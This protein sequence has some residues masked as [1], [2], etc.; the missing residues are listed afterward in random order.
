MLKGYVLQAYLIKYLIKYELIAIGV[1]IAI[2][3]FVIWFIIVLN[4]VTRVKKTSLEE[5]LAGSH[6][7]N[8]YMLSETL[9][10]TR[11]SA[12]S[13]PESNF[14]YLKGAIASG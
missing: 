7:Y 14:S 10:F 5:I 3:T 9:F 13:S 4:K 11:A 6:A 8:A 2:S 1:I 12:L